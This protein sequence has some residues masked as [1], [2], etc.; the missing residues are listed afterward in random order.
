MQLISSNELSMLVHTHVGV[1][2]LGG[3]TVMF[4]ARML[5]HF[6]LGLTKLDA[7]H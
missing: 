7:H 5:R 4:S 6:W 3:V 1:L 2:P